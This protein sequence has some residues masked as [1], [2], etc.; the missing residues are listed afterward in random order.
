[1]KLKYLFLSIVFFQA[2]LS[3][4]QVSSDQKNTDIAPV[5][6]IY[7]DTN[8][9]LIFSGEYLYYS[10]YCFDT[11]T[12]ALSE[13]SKMA[14]VEL[15]GKNGNSVFKHKIKLEN[16]RGYSDFF[17]PVE[18]A[19]GNYKLVAYTNWM[20][21][22]DINDLSVTDITVINPYKVNKSARVNDDVKKD[23]NLKS[24]NNI[25]S[26]KEDNPLFVLKLDRERYQK[27]DK[28]SLKLK[29]ISESFNN[30]SGTYSLSVKRKTNIPYPKFKTSVGY[31]N[32]LK[33][34]YL[35]LSEL[36][37]NASLPELRGELLKGKIVSKTNEDVSNLRVAISITNESNILRIAESDA[38][39]YFYFNIDSYYDTNTIYAQVLG[40]N[41][42]NYSISIEPK[43]ELKTKDLEFDD[44]QLLPEWEDEIVNQ[45][46]YNQIESAYFEFRSDSLFLTSG[47]DFLESKVPET[48][49]LDDYTRFKTLE[50]T[51]KEYIKNVSIS[52]DSGK[53]SFQ[54][55]G[56]EFDSNTGIKPLV[57]LDGIMIDNQDALMSY[58]ASTIEEIKIYREQFVVDLVEFQGVIV[59]NSISDYINT[60]FETSRLKRLNISKPEIKKT[61]YTQSYSV[62]NEDSRLPDYRQQLLWIPMLDLS[63]EIE[64]EI[65]FFTSDVKGI[66][67]IKLEG[68]TFD[69]QPI[70][71]RQQ[72]VVD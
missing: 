56:Y 19:T 33:P 52:R 20:K 6:S 32:E 10:L 50:E 15:I 48:Y 69:G 40:K 44:F 37:N 29:V 39:G 60:F 59:I 3:F 70:S 13:L 12:K 18:V 57:L 64:K 11:S 66:Y 63:D 46:I 55:Q 58:N 7:L 28:V 38:Q 27:R 24:V 1:M 42:N 68:F 67:E 17:M 34:A 21:N 51:V 31:F 62:G 54:I 35:K 26:R 65:S 2:K 14:Y 5:E 8:A 49:N 23:S 53:K 16:G 4:G 9:A 36:P 61:Y 45:S 47:D 43:S 30:L 22:K 25:P 41:T 72:I 71:L